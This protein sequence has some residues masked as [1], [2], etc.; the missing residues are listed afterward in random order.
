MTGDRVSDDAVVQI[1]AGPPAEDAASI[2][3]TLE[4][5]DTRGVSDTLNDAADE[6]SDA[7]R[8]MRGIIGPFSWRRVAR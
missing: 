1:D 8:R 5:E 6:V 3:D 4:I 2:Q 7:W